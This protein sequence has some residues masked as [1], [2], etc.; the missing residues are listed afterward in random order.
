MKRTIAFLLCIC[1]LLC[2]CGQS[3]HE[4]ADTATET[5]ESET[6]PPTVSSLDLEDV[7][8]I[9]K[10]V[11]KDTYDDVTVTS[12]GD[13]VVIDFTYPGLASAVKDILNTRSDALLGA[14]DQV[15]DSIKTLSKTIL[16]NAKESGIENVSILINVN[17]DQ[18]PENT[19]LIIFN[20]SV[21]YDVVN[22][23]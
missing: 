13:T 12:E 19:L 4:S 11:L 14:W 15:V 18:N 7:A 16:N 5:T 3:S 1:L 9:A 6:E 17:N 21:I 2:G 20:D 23:K 22:S 8:L 10:N